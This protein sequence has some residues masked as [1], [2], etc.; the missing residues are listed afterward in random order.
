MLPILEIWPQ[1][2]N[3]FQTGKTPLVEAPPGTGKTTVLP[4][5]NVRYH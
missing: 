4:L 1:I 2:Q 5:K 3:A